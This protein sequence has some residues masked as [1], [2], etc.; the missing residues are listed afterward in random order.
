MGLVQGVVRRLVE[1]VGTVIVGKEEQTPT[2]DLA[3][4]KKGSRSPQGKDGQGKGAQG[5]GTQGLGAKNGEGDQ[6]GQ[7]GPPAQGSEQS[8]SAAKSQP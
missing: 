4:R 3:P 5:K 7:A 8:G 6:K 1:S 2:A